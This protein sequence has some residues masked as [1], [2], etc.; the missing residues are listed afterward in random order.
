M[1][2][3]ANCSREF[4]ADLVDSWVQTRLLS[5]RRFQ[6]LVIVEGDLSMLESNEYGP[7]TP[8]LSY[9]VQR[10]LALATMVRQV[11][12]DKNIKQSAKIRPLATLRLCLR[13]QLP[14]LRSNGLQGTA[15]LINVIALERHEKS[16][17]SALF[18]L[19]KSYLNDLQEFPK[20]MKGKPFQ[21]SIR[22][23]RCSECAKTDE[24]SDCGGSGVLT[25]IMSLSYKIKKSPE[26]KKIQELRKI[27]YPQER[28]FRPRRGEDPKDRWI[29]IPFSF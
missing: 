7:S 18:V 23:D 20:F 28:P 24:K 1:W 11:T 13:D 3:S 26:V 29:F 12:C 21:Y 2:L 4:P 19:S 16:E 6:S 9:E 10:R 17:Q 22:K 5:N 14:V 8:T 15:E 25:L 27:V